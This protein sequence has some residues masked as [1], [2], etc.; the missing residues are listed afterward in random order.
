MLVSDVCWAVNYNIF[1]DVNTSWRQC[2]SIAV[3]Q[4]RI[5]VIDLKQ[6]TTY[7]QINYSE[8]QVC[9]I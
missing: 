3:D 2:D 9:V 7:I 6:R 4:R 1:G 5:S 8:V